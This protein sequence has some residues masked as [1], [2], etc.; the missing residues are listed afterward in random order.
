MSPISVRAKKCTDLLTQCSELFRQPDHEDYS[1]VSSDEISDSLG[2]FRIW[3]G[4]IGAL[5]QAEVKSSLD[6]RVRDTPKIAAQIS[7]ILDDFV[8]SLE[9]GKCSNS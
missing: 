4:N 9:D 5:Q 2:R 7:K 1:G 8:E 6:H 3:A